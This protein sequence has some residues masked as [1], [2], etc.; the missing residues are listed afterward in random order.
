MLY[1]FL[2]PYA[3]EVGFFNLFR[4]LTFRTGGAILTAL[5]LSFWLGQPI[6]NWLKKKQ[7][8]GQPIREDGPETH[9]MTKKGTPTMGGGLIL[10]ALTLSTLLWASY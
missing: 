6:I 5:I 4:Y 10:L 2:F 7:G 9:L 1:Y 3:G 8:Q